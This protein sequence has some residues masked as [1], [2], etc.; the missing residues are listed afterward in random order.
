MEA[1]MPGTDGKL[2]PLRPISFTASELVAERVVARLY[3][4]PPKG[5]SWRDYARHE[6]ALALRATAARTKESGS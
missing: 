5:M 3:K 1:A 6:I 2:G 4:L